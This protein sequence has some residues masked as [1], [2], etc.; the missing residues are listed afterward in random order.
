M[1]EFLAQSAERA[2]ARAVISAANAAVEN[3]V[4]PFRSP[5][6]AVARDNHIPADRKR[7][8]RTGGR[9]KG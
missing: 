6:E 7:R 5:L 8:G 4:L 2:E 3:K 9:S 1:D